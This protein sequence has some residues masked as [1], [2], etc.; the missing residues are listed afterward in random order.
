MS[1]RILIV[2]DD[3]DGMAVVMRRAVE[4]AYPGAEVKCVGILDEALDEIAK[5]PPYD[6]ALVDLNLIGPTPDKTSNPAKT[7]A[8]IP[9]MSKRTP[10]LIVTGF[11][12]EALHSGFPM[13]S[14]NE[15][16][17]TAL[18]IAIGKLLAQVGGAW[19]RADQRFEKMDELEG[20]IAD[21]SQE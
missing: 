18:P 1:V 8:A 9:E 13:L 11:P 6:V 12:D 10:V 16:M 15:S 3:I 14:K 20:R 5:D 21:A 4:D 2:E 7:L 17:F 19:K